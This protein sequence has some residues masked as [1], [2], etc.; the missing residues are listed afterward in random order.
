MITA[1]GFKPYKREIDRESG[2]IMR[3]LPLPLRFAIKAESASKGFPCEG[4]CRNS[5]PSRLGWDGDT[6]CSQFSFST[7]ATLGGIAERI[8]SKGL[9][10]H[11][12]AT[13]ANRFNDSAEATE[14]GE[15]IFVRGFKPPIAE[16]S[17]TLITRP[18][19]S[20]PPNGT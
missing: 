5:R 8:R 7:D 6:S 1:S 10:A 12:V 18:S 14:I 3:I 11:A 4:S 20:R 15:S 2:R 16:P 17:R 19:T 13:A 9:A